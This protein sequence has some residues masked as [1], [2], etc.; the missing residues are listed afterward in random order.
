MLNYGKLL[1]F[2]SKR[3]KAEDLLWECG[4]VLADNAL[5]VGG[6]GE[7][8]DEYDGD[9]GWFEFGG[10]CLDGVWGGVKLWLWFVVVFGTHDWLLINSSITLSLFIT[11][12]S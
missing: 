12:P 3:W 1:W 9:E 8:G 6:E 11:K 10:F 2:I 4:V 7:T 5:E